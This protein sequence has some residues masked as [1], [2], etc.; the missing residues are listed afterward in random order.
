MTIRGAATAL[1]LLLVLAVVTGCASVPGDSPVQVLRQVGRGESAADL[2]PPDGS[3]PLDMV[4]LFVTNSAS[5]TDK[6]G[7]A[8]RF[9]TTEAAQSWHDDASLTIL[10]GQIDT[11]PAPGAPDISTG[12]TTIRIRGNKIG[13][14]TDDGAF[15]PDQATFQLDV[16]IV[17][18][19]GQWRISQLPPGVV[20]SLTD[21]RGNYHDVSPWFVDNSRRLVVADPRHI[22]E[23]PIR[24][25]AARIVAMVLAGPSLA[26]NGA[27]VSMIPT[28]AR[29]RSNVAAGEDG[30]LVVDLT[31][32]GDL[33]D[34][35]RRLIAAQLVM[36]L[37]E[38]NV[39]KVRL[40]VDGE[41]LL[42][43]GPA[44]W[45]R[46]DVLRFSAEAPVTSNVPTLV[47]SGGR[48]LQVGADAG[49]LPGPFGNGSYAAESAAAT[50]DGRR[51]AVV[52][53][54]GTGRILLVSGGADAGVAPVPLSAKS[55]SRPTWTPS[56]GEVWTVL[57]GTSIARVSIDGNGNYRTG[58]VNDTELT[59]LGPI[60][61]LRLS[62]DGMRVA[63]VVG[64]GL[65]V[66]A[67]ERSIDGEVA[68]HNV[69]RLR[70]SELTAVVGVDWQTSEQIAVI[71]RQQSDQLVMQIAADG[72]TV[73][74]V[75]I[76]NLTPPL[77]AVA[78][79]PSRPLL[80]TDQTGVWS[81]VGGE[82]A[83]WKLVVGGAPDAIPVYPG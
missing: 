34:E 38:V 77:S 60:G 14:L 16:V 59:E 26:L 39:P 76:N 52:A 23:V 37:A 19:D 24:S 47:V 4:R 20:V 70:A 66:G 32:T 10:D 63:A 8:R 15:E 48:V 2:P 27:V 22:P 41:P 57:D 80:V 72:L 42:P 81:Y 43:G 74:E 56:G 78:A 33:D 79:S 53:R 35:T 3:D 9:L 62:R 18:H 67:V 13:K 75:P 31:R 25:W 17:R 36:S 49:A 46:D 6:H 1:A 12:T 82:Q 64:G 7:A 40:L 44:I 55:M 83:T 65:Y 61:D 50:V 29:L 54:S 21:F 28:T 71:T 69:R 58:D 45:T 30:V 5:S 51:L 68:I 11:V 73:Q